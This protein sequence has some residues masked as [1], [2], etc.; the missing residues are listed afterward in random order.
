MLHLRLFE[1]VVLALII[2]ALAFFTRQSGFFRVPSAPPALWRRIAAL[3]PRQCGIV[4]AF[5]LAL[6]IILFMC[7]AFFGSR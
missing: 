6:I 1:V 5:L 7:L 4:V 2:V 3:T